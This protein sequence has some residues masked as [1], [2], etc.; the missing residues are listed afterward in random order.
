MY[1]RD[2]AECPWEESNI[3]IKFFMIILSKQRLLICVSVYV[4]MLCVCLCVVYVCLRVNACVL[5]A[6][7]NINI[8]NHY[9]KT[10]RMEF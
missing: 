5:C 6:A 7:T 3:Y 8:L 2:N 4:C 10:K 1:Q 9:S